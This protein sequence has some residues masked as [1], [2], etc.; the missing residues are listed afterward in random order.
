MAKAVEVL[1]VKMEG[2]EREIGDWR[3]S[4]EGMD[5]KL[6]R[7]R[8]DMVKNNLPEIR[9]PTFEEITPDAAA[10]VRPR[11]FVRDL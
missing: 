1:G 4:K 9:E 8:L 3:W 10:R 5:V 7:E 11:L 6:P 2:E